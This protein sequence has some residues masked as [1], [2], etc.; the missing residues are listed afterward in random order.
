MEDR[1]RLLGWATGAGTMALAAAIVALALRLTQANSDLWLTL[2]W[3]AA[4]MV[5]LALAL[6]GATLVRAVEQINR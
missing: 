6:V 4:V 3:F 1:N 5:L 2:M